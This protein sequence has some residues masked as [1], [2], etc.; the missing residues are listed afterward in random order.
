MKRFIL[1]VSLLCA[2]V[3]GPAQNIIQHGDFTGVTTMT[4]DSYLY[5]IANLNDL[6]KDIQG[7][8][9]E[10]NPVV[11]VTKG[12]WYKKAGNNGSLKAQ[13]VNDIPYPLGS[14]SAVNL[15]KTGSAPVSA[16]QNQLIQYFSVTDGA[17]YK[18]EFDIRTE[19]GLNNYSD[20]NVQ[21]RA[22]SG[23]GT[24]AFMNA[25]NLSMTDNS[26]FQNYG[27]GWLRFSRTFTAFNSTLTQAQFDNSMLVIAKA[28]AG[29]PY[30]YY[31]TN[32]KLEKVSPTALENDKFNNSKVVALNNQIR[33][34][35]FDGQVSVFNV[36]GALVSKTECKQNL[37]VNMPTQGIFIVRLQ[38]DGATKTMKVVL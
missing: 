33:V 22:I 28:S 1:S 36:A 20:I 29:D 15:I 16:D 3:L 10:V 14:V 11:V 32:V 17:E 35:D 8:N 19:D 7:Q 31:I 18:L 21:L 12:N 26:V 5:R 25:N 38:K 2:F 37:V 4:S 34:T 23:N 6:G 30:S 24:V 27:N 13:V 9:P